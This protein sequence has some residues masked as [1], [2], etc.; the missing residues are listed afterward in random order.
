MREAI[1]RCHLGHF[2]RCQ[3]LAFQITDDILGMFGDPLKTGK[4]VG[5]NVSR[6]K[7]SYPVLAALASGHP[8]SQE[9][10]ELYSQPMPLT[11]HQIARVGTLVECAGGKHLAEEGPS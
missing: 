9:L 8:A 2:G 3:G 6:C 7:K 10:A 5:S 4:P 11:E 1:A